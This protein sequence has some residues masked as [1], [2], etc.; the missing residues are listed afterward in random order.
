MEFILYSLFALRLSMSLCNE[1]LFIVLRLSIGTKTFLLSFFLSL[2]LIGSAM[3]QIVT[4]KPPVEPPIIYEKDRQAAETRISF[5]ESLVATS[6]NRDSF[7]N[8][9]KLYR[10]LDEEPE[11]KLFRKRAFTLDPDNTIF[12]NDVWLWEESATTSGAS[13]VK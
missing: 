12:Q 13:A 10:Y 4:R 6:P 11:A 7:L 8:L 3:S 1:L 9:E 5:W 2:M